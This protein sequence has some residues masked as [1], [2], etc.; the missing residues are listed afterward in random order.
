MGE[1]IKRVR[2]EALLFVLEPRIDTSGVI[3]KKYIR[4]LNCLVC[5]EFVKNAIIAYSLNE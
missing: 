5:K 2:E 3:F 1:I 4:E